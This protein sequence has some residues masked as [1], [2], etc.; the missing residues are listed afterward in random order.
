M[1]VLD[2]SVVIAHFNPGDAH[3]E[4]AFSVLDTEE[5]L[6][7]HPLTLSEFLTRPIRDGRH[8]EALDMLASIGI[9]RWVPDHDEP[10]RVAQLRVSTGL[11]LPDC[12]VLSAAISGGARLATF[13][14]RLAAA[15]R[16]EGVS[17]IE[18]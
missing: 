13:D 17:V 16:N 12:C 18:A 9:D 5:E 4:R 15:A 10:V 2:A 8:G 7:V 1:I 3:A 11:K 14:S 6:A